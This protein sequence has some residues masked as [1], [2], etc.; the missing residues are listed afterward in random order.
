MPA[1]DVLIRWPLDWNG[2]KRLRGLL[3]VGLTIYGIATL[4]LVAIFAFAPMS[5]RTFMHLFSVLLF[6]GRTLGADGNLGLRTGPER[7]GKHVQRWNAA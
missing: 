3:D 1:A 6:V 5:A 2:P 4:A 7:S